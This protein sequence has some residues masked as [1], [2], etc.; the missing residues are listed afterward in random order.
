MSKLLLS[1]VC[2]LMMVMMMMMMMVMVVVVVMCVARGRQVNSTKHANWSY[3]TQVRSRDTERTA[4]QT[5]VE[6]TDL[7]CRTTRC[8]LS[9]IDTERDTH[10]ELCYISFDSRDITLTININKQPMNHDAQL[11]ATY[12]EQ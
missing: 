1:H 11:T 8:L 3:N 4:N 2:Q 6:T 9:N 10:C 7:I 5:S 12:I